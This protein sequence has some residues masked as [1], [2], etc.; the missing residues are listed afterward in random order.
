M[1]EAYVAERVR[2]GFGPVRI[3]QELRS[4]GLGDGLIETHLKRSKQEWLSSMVSAHDKRFGEAPP[5]G[6]RE[7]AQRAR[8][9][10]YRGFP[11]EL[12]AGFLRGDPGR[13]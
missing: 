11:A 9:L 13:H 6:A 1:A 2:K 7:K 3:H 10:E 5:A 8:F 12:I 4:R